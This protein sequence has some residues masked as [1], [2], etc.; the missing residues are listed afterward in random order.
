MKRVTLFLLVLFLSI[1]V[2]AY[3]NIKVHQLIN[4][5]AALQS[6]NF[7]STMKALG[8]KGNLPNEIIE[9]N[10]LKGKKIKDLFEEGGK[11]EDETACRSKFHFHDPTKSFDNAGLNNVLVDTGCLDFR[12]RSSLIWAQDIDNLW[13]WQKARQYYY[14][15]MTSSDKDIREQIFAYAIRTLGQVMHL[16]ADSSVPEH[17]RN[18]IHIL[19][20]L[21]NPDKTFPQI[22]RWTYETWCKYNFS[23]LNTT[24]DAIDYSVTNNSLIQGLVPITNFWDTTPS[25]GYN[26]N[27][28]GLAE[29][30][31]LNFL[32]K[33]TIFKDYSYPQKPSSLFLES[34]T[35]EDGKA[36]YRVYF[37]GTTSD[38]QSI[39]HLASTGYLW[40]ELSEGNPNGIDDSRFNL[41]DDCFKD[42]ASVL[43][44]KAV[45]YSAALLN[46]F[47]RGSIEVTLKEIGG[48]YGSGIYTNHPDGEEHYT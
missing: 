18:D 14:Q 48:V 45:G 26:L 31:N 8:F 28:I 47:F 38:G 30:S 42:Y 41:D 7:T 40:S 36:D 21:D 37:K 46:Y 34:V 10:V 29:Y 1:N 2:Y 23:T 27:P 6:S 12:H 5:N 11:L 13:S 22:G 15:A 33:D 16:L 43:I 24:S 32:S 17:T 44:P 39:N 19:P 20:L 25:P 3:D 9:L 35:A 4:V